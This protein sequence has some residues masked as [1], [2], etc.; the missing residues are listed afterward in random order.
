MYTLRTAS[1][2]DITS[3]ADTTGASF[4]NESMAPR[5]SRIAIS[6]ARPG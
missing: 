6:A 4:G 5:P 3:A 2:I 1:T